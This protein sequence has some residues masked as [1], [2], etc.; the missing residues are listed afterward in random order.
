VL[1]RRLRKWLGPT[2]A[3]FSALASAHRFRYDAFSNFYFPDS[4]RNLAEC[5]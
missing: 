4:E 5:R 3:R 1:R 2:L